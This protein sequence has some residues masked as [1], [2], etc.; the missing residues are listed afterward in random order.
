MQRAEVKYPW[1]HYFHVSVDSVIRDG[2]GAKLAAVLDKSGPLSLLLVTSDLLVCQVL[3][4]D[5]QLGGL[6][7]LDVGK[8]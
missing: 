1:L 2:L 7:V 5:G 6:W 3:A 4:G 8:R